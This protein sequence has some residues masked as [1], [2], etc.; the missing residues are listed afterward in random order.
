METF[1]FEIPISTQDLVDIRNIKNIITNNIK[2]ETEPGLYETSLEETLK[3]K[4]SLLYTGD[5]GAPDISDL[6]FQ[7][8][9]PG[10][11][12]FTGSFILQ[13]DIYR[14]YGCSDLSPTSEDYLKF[15]YKVDRKTLVINC[16]T[17]DLIKSSYGY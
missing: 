3:Y 7:E 10:K 11:N 14:H 2:I 12:K 1:K 17:S 16:T 6:Q 13:Y 4:L 8:F 5:G 9:E 15:N